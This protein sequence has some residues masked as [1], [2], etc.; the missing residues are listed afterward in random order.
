MA[1]DRFRTCAGTSA[2]SS[3]VDLSQCGKVLT[4]ASIRDDL[5]QQAVPLIFGMHMYASSTNLTIE[6]EF[7]SRE[8]NVW[9]GT[10]LLLR[11]PTVFRVA[12]SLGL[13]SISRLGSRIEFDLDC[14]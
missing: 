14:N 9:N 5:V 4:D 2:V 11:L 7:G 12:A 13:A 10:F 1:F 6:F 3:S 8:C